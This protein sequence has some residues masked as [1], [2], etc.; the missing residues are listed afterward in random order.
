MEDKLYRTILHL[1]AIQLAC[2]LA[3]QENT[4]KAI[5]TMDKEAQEALEFAVYQL[6]RKLH[7]RNR[8][9]AHRNKI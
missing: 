7:R 4:D 1:K 9:N 2:L 3:A 5:I 6:E 8:K